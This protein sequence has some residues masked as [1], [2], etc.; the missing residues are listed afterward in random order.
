MKSRK[1]GGGVR[2]VS[3]DAHPA[4]RSWRGLRPALAG[5]RQ[6]LATS[7]PGLEDRA[8]Q[9]HRSGRGLTAVRGVGLSFNSAKDD[10]A[11]LRWSALPSDRTPPSTRRPSLFLVAQAGVL[12]DR[13]RLPGERCA[14]EPKGHP[15]SVCN[16]AYEA[17]MRRPITSRMHAMLDY[18]LAVVLIA[19][20]WIFGFSDVGGAAVAL[21]IIV[22]ALALGQSLI[23]DWELSVANI[24]PPGAFDVDALAGVVLAISPFVF[25]FYDEGTNVWLPQVV[26]GIGMLNAGLMTQRD[27]E[28]PPAAPARPP[29]TTLDRCTPP[30][31]SASGR[32][33]RSCASAP[34]CPPGCAPK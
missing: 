4:D 34:A 26:A 28:A 9:D 29:C 14:G 21:P 18:P 33:A 8:A 32:A 12:A 10:S 1:R 2:L 6:A 19:T 31:N 7:L 3:E 22:G 5:A 23:T 17:D 15:D 16:A 24:I 13:Q 30:P 27:A 25:G 20:P 11:P